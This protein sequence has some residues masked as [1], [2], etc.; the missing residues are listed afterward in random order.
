[1]FKYFLF[2]L[3]SILH[4]KSYYISTLVY[5][6]TLILVTYMFPAI[7]KQPFINVLTQWFIWTMV[8]LAIAITITMSTIYV[9]K[10]GIE[11]GTEVLISS[12]PISRVECIWA[13]L[14]LMFIIILFQ[15]FVSFIIALFLPLAKYGIKEN[16]PIAGGFF[17]FSFIVSLFFCAS[18]M[19]FALISKQQAAMFLNFS[20]GFLLVLITSINVI[21]SKTPGKIINEQGYSLTNKMYIPA[22]DKKTNKKHLSEGYLL[23]YKNKVITKN[24]MELGKDVDFNKL[25]KDIYQN[26][27]N[28]SSFVKTVNL[29]PAFQWIMLLNISNFQLQEKTSPFWYNDLSYAFNLAFANIA[30]LNFDVPTNKEFITIKINNIQNQGEIQ[31]YVPI[32]STSTSIGVLNDQE[33]KEK[34]IFSIPIIKETRFIFMPQYDID[35]NT[36]LPNYNSLRFN[37]FLVDEIMNNSQEFKR[38]YDYIFGA[39]NSLYSEYILK[40]ENFKK[41]LL[42]YAINYNFLDFVQEKVNN[43]LNIVLMNIEN[44]PDGKLPLYYKGNPIIEN[45]FAVKPIYYKS[46][47]EE[48]KKYDN[49]FDYSIWKKI[50][51]SSLSW[52]LMVSTTQTFTARLQDIFSEAIIKQ[53]ETNGALTIDY[54]EENSKKIIDFLMNKRELQYKNANPVVMTD[55]NKVANIDKAINQLKDIQPTDPTFIKK[56]IELDYD[57][58]QN[59]LYFNSNF[60]NLDN[61]DNF[62]SFTNIKLD[63]MINGYG[64]V[65]GWLSLSSILILMASGVY[66]RKDFK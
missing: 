35:N 32:G 55:V 43:A 57:I 39:N 37:I 18:G 5:F 33:R 38:F 49:D 61:L 1:M 25:I 31:N 34:P 26:A 53:Q 64:L 21:L 63:Y 8:V 17:L 22:Y 29:D 19:L 59:S 30:K 10:S 3:K 58:K 44:N 41:S 48:I 13:K 12:K 47:K 36:F 20:L 27:Y 46:L 23:K 51:F 52:L 4:K 24:S 15:S 60:Y 9:F 42:Q 56:Q 11:D 62:T 14:L 40:K 66:A 65:V 45:N 54:N 7:L 6:V 28:E 2:S 50:D 16:M